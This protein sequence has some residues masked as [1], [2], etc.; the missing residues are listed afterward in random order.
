MTKKKDKQTPE[1]IAGV[2]FDAE[3]HMKEVAQKLEAAENPESRLERL[4]EL[5]QSIDQLQEINDHLDVKKNI[6]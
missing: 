2:I 6:H 1:K 4:R 5:T 3:K